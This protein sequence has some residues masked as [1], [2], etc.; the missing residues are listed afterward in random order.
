MKVSKYKNNYIILN[1]SPHSVNKTL[2]IFVNYFQ[3]EF[4]H[5]QKLSK[6]F[7]S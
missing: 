7:I 5:P 1:T 3:T 2:K 6:I 4:I